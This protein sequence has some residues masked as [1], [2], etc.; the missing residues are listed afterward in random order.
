MGKFGLSDG[1]YT[2]LILKLLVYGTVITIIGLFVVKPF[3]VPS[4]DNV[5]YK[6]EKTP[7]RMAQ[8]TLIDELKSC[9]SKFGSDYKDRNQEY[10]NII[11]SSIKF[12]I[13]SGHF[14][15]SGGEIS[16]YNQGFNKTTDIGDIFERAKTTE[17]KI[18]NTLDKVRATVDE[19]TG[20]DI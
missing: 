3:L 16:A 17:E 5:V 1:D 10:C 8:E 20:G 7:K 15:L 19:I 14:E 9:E 11:L 4:S 12:L 2:F 6:C 13:D 18:D